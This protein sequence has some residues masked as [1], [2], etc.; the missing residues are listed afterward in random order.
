M[1]L[2]VLG[3]ASSQ[4]IPQPLCSCRLCQL[5][6]QQNG[7]NRRLRS[8]YLVTLNSGKRILL[9]ISPDFASQQIK[10]GFNF[11]YL[12]L[13]HRHRDHLA[14]LAELR[15]DLGAFQRRRHKWERRRTF[16]L[17]KT[18]ARWLTQKHHDVYWQESLQEAYQQLTSR[19]FFRS[20]ILDPFQPL[21][22]KIGATLTYLRGYHGEIYSGGLLIKE[23][24]SSLAYL[25]DIGYLNSKLS[26][27]L[28]RMNPNL[29]IA[30]T[31]FFGQP[32]E[33]TDSKKHLS[34]ETIQQIPAQKI[35]L[36]HFSHRVALPHQKLVQK[37]KKL[38]PRLIVAFDGQIIDL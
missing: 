31:P 2:L 11:D 24:S 19:G 35:L 26:R 37:A 4:G 18:L 7:F 10:F 15:V 14:G 33:D 6:R 38:D 22:L 9:D 30:H 28:A 5:A 20:L 36:S 21:K 8:S 23:G 29:V 3:S 25:G 16:L 13:S 27:F 12:F 32:P 34:A 1:Q 17:G